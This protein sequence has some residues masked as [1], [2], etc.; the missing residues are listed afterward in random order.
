MSNLSRISQLTGESLLHVAND[1]LNRVQASRIPFMRKPTSR[2]MV[3]IFFLVCNP[4]I[5]SFLLLT[6]LL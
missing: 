3:S 2:C 4:N 5:S 6:P 1:N